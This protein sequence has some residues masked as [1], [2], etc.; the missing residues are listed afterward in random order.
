[1]GIRPRA[2]ITSPEDRHGCG[3]ILKAQKGGQRIQETR[4]LGSPGGWSGRDSPNPNRWVEGSAWGI[5]PS[6]YC[7]GYGHRVSLMPSFQLPASKRAVFLRWV[8]VNVDGARSRE[9][10]LG[11]VRVSKGKV[12]VLGDGTRVRPGTG[13]L[14]T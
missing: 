2:W 5:S 10:S 7:R 11:W 12:E 4:R 13:V 8:R 9:V 1:M 6:W 3:W 14:L